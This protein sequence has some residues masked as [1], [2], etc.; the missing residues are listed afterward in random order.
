M[1][2]LLK[3]APFAQRMFTE[4]LEGIRINPMNT[5]GDTEGLAWLDSMPGQAPFV[6][7]TR[8]G[9]YLESPWLV[10]QELP[11][12]TCSELNAAL[13]TDLKRGQT[14]IHLVLDEASRRGL[15]P[16]GAAVGQVGCGGTSLATLADLEEALAGIGLARLPLHIQAG[17]AALP[18][19]ALLVAFW[20]KQDIRLEALQ[21]CLGLDPAAELARNGSLSGSLSGINRE[22]GVLTRWAISNAPELKTLPVVEDPWH[23][24]GADSALS[25]G[26]TLAAAVQQLRAMEKEGLGIEESSTRVQFNLSI[27]PDF[28]MEIAKIRA[29]RLLWHDVLQA[30]DCGDLAAEM[31]IHARTSRRSASALDPHVN[32]LRVTTQA[33]SAVLAGVDSLHVAPFDGVNGSPDEFSRR[34]ARNLQLILARECR[35]DQVVDPAGGSHYVETLTADLAAAAWKIFQDVEQAGGVIAALESGWIQEKIAAAAEARTA[36]LAVRDL[37]MVGTNQYANPSE[38]DRPLRSLDFTSLHASRSDQVLQIRQQE[39]SKHFRETWARL[40]EAW[41]SDPDQVLPLMAEAVTH[42]ATLGELSA[43]LNEGQEPRTT[44]PVI[45][46]V[47]DAE[48]FEILR[49]RVG[50]LAVA[51]PD[52]GRVFCACLGDSARYMS[53][54][55]FAR[56]LFAVGGFEVQADRFFS[57]AESAARAAVESNSATVVVVGL[58]STYEELGVSTV[59]LLKALDRPPRIMLAGRPKGLVKELEQA[60]VEEFIHARSDVLEVLGQL[61]DSLAGPE[62]RS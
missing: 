24:A 22:L 60:G 20:N 9:G 12:P 2:R 28:F 5:A 18:M 44:V 17:R 11:L 56:R 39:K 32:L 34:I 40:T 38:P 36:K 53:R 33:M 50:E 19:A 30:M 41:R 45:A 58:D 10:A 48:P 49:G 43:F 52:A 61:A 21:G 62:V 59:A 25:L 47:R 29:L 37:V 35:F 55:D 31:K 7:G 14:A 46:S 51:S 4:T 27:G 15:D 16:D 54:L 57:D 26:L 6:R 1:E 42:G 23:T 13:V 8:A 3:G